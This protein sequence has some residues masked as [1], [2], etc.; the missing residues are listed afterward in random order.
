MGGVL[1]SGIWWQ[2]RNDGGQE[3][4]TPR[5]PSHYMGAPNHCGGCRMTAESAEKSQQCLKYLLQY[6]TFASEN[7]SFEHGGAKLASCPGRYL[8]SLRPCV[9]VI[10][11]WCALFL[12]PQFDVIFM[13]PN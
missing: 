5:A 3:G 8:T 13:F 4:A 10:C 11:I 7:L 2:G 9:V 1:F 12:T 6:S